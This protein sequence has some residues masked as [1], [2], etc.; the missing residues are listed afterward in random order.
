MKGKLV[1]FVSLLLLSMG[2]V[3][4][5]RAQ[6]QNTAEDTARV[7]TEYEITIYRKAKA[8]LV[9]PQEYQF[10][11]PDMR[12]VYLKVS[13]AD[14]G[15]LIG[16][17]GSYVR[18]A[19]KDG[20][21]GPFNVPSSAGG[22]SL[23]VTV[24]DVTA[25]SILLGEPFNI[26]FAD[27]RGETI[28]PASSSS[29]YITVEE[30]SEFYVKVT[31]KEGAA[32]AGA[33]V[34]YRDPR[35]DD[36]TI[37]EM[38]KTDGEGIAGPYTLWVSATTEFTFVAYKE[39]EPM[40]AYETKAQV[41]D[42]ISTPMTPEE[43]QE[44]IEEALPVPPAL[45]G[46]A[47]QDVYNW[48]AWWYNNFV[49]YG[50]TTRLGYGDLFAIKN[51][52]QIVR[53]LP[54][55]I[56]AFPKYWVD[57]VGAV[58][59]TKY[60]V[61]VFVELLKLIPAMIKLL[62]L[63][64]ETAPK[65]MLGLYP[66]LWMRLPN[67][68]KGINQAVVDTAILMLSVAPA[69][70][71]VL[72]EYLTKLPDAIP[73]AGDIL[74]ETIIIFLQSIPAAA[75]AL[76]AVFLAIPAFLMLMFMST[77]IMLPEFVVKVLPIEIPKVL[78]RLFALWPMYTTGIAAAFMAGAPMMMYFEP[79]IIIPAIAETLESSVATAQNMMDALRRMPSELLGPMLSGIGSALFSINFA[80]G[81]IWMVVGSLL[82][83]PL[84]LASI[85][86][87][88]LILGIIGFFFV[89]PAV[90]SFL[91]GLASIIPPFSW[92]VGS[93]SAVWML[94]SIILSV[95]MAFVYVVVTAVEL[96]FID[97]CG[98]VF[99]AFIKPTVEMALPLVKDMLG[100]LASGAGELM[101]STLGG[102]PDIPGAIAPFLAGVA[103]PL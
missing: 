8:N 40:G 17:E 56:S 101:G 3:D 31:S 92:I 24:N 15:D 1:L 80:F 67:M 6:A 59:G 79:G 33:T 49:F 13:P 71:E 70:M 96:C 46:N 86:V 25:G 14:S 63:I 43:L 83:L 22:E 19:D 50:G 72:P 74:L 36:G 28:K 41:R 84:V 58:V 52:T 93:L 61:D 45:T 5:A 23:E 87:G 69:L 98:N 102:V 89:L 29:R 30:G 88:G 44:E 51:W 7:A 66:S 97:P 73:K 12:D 54:Q 16:L 53:D 82:Q 65:R 99:A 48:L 77:F 34:G 62:P 37:V 39:E 57:P 26:A 90:I 42:T 10:V 2:F 68:L 64:I 55:L 95:L 27:S 85:I 91:I 94:G 100:L 20:I 38:K 4:S 18:Q 47:T 35:S 60:M 78:T 32:V 103:T 76:P 9:V 81:L 75:R 11:Y 21:A